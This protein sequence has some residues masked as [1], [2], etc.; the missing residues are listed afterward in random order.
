M[1]IVYMNVLKIRW[2]LRCVCDPKS[3][4]ES[5]AATDKAKSRFFLLLRALGKDRHTRMLQQLPVDALPF[6]TDIVQL[7]WMTDGG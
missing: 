5:L 4:G 2:C 1:A 7:V 3:L 6:F